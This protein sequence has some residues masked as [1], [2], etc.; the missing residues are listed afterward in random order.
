MLDALRI[1]PDGTTTRLT[2]PLQTAEQAR[3]LREQVGGFVEVAKYGRT[4]GDGVAIGASFIVH[5]TGARDLPPNPYATRLA[6]ALA[7][8]RLPYQLHGP[9]VLLGLPNTAGELGSLTGN[10]RD[11]A[12][13]LSSALREAA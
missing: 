4:D 5:E 7:R 13:A 10:V 12:E 1:D 2:L 11:T 3:A 8:R 9:I 6:A